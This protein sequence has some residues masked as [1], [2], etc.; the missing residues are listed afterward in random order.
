MVHG[1][2]SPFTFFIFQQIIIT[3]PLLF[4]SLLS[5]P[6][7]S[8]SPG[9]ILGLWGFFHIILHIKIL[10][11]ILHFEY[12]TLSCCLMTNNIFDGSVLKSPQNWGSVLL[13][14]FISNV[15]LNPFCL[16][17]ILNILQ[18]FGSQTQECHSWR[19]TDGAEG[20]S[21]TL[22]NCWQQV[23]QSYWKRVWASQDY[24]SG[25]WGLFYFIFNRGMSNGPA[26]W[27]HR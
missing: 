16:Y 26:K 3:N 11:K 9:K 27:L 12:F 15:E 1:I 23:E 19:A 7:I 24:A 17:D 5:E 4:T 20:P 21:E 6:S 14:I 2:Y 22:L 18:S 8:L 25:I 10:I 13:S